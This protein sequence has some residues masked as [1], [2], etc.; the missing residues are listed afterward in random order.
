[1]SPRGGILLAPVTAE[2]VVDV[3]AGADEDPRPPGG[4]AVADPILSAVSPARFV[5]AGTA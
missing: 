1:M 5:T 3:L 4:A 2:L